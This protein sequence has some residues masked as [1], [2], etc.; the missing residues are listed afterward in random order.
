PTEQTTTPTTTSSEPPKETG[1]P[2]QGQILDGASTEAAPSPTVTPEQP[3][4]GVL[5]ASVLQNVEA[6]SLDLDNIDP[7]NSATLSTDK[8]D[9]APTDTAII[10]G[11]GFK[12]N[13]D[14]NITVSSADEPAT[15]T[16]D[17]ITTDVDG[18]FVY[19]YQL[20]GIYRPNYKVVVTNNGGHTIAATTFTD[21]AAVDQYSQCANDTGTGYTS[22]D[23]GCQWINGNLQS[24]NSAY[25][26]G[27]ATPQRL[28]LTGLINGTHTVVI[29]YGTT[30]GGKH[31]YDFVTDDTFSESWI[32]NAEFCEGLTGFGDCATLTPNLSSLI[33]TD[34]NA[35]GFDVA[36]ANR[37]F[38]IR[39]G[40]FVSVGTPTLISGSY[41]GDSETTILLTFNVD[42]NTC[43]NKVVDHGKNPN[44]DECPV[45]ITW[46]EHVSKQSDW[47]TGNSAVNISGSPYHVSLETVDGAS[48]GSRDNQMQAGAI[49][50]SI[51]II[52]DSQPNSA[53]DFSFT[54]TRTGLTSF[55]LDDDAD[56]TLS[57]TKFFG[58]LDAG[59][60][61]VSEI[62]ATGWT[63]SNITCVDPTQNSTSGLP[64]APTA[65][66]NLAAGENITCTFTNTQQN[67]HLTVQ[68]TT[69]PA[70]S[71]QSF[72]ITATGSGTI[73]GG[74]AGSITDSTDQTYEVTAGT[75]S[76]SETV[77]T[78]WTQTSNTCSNVVVAAGG[79]STCLITNTQKGHIVVRKVT[80]GADDTFTFT[81]G[82]TGYNGFSLSHGQSNDQEVIPGSYTVSE[83][84]LSGWSSDGGSCDN[85]ETPNSLDVEAG[86]TVTCTFTNTK[87]RNITA[88]KYDD[89]NG[90]GT[91][92]TSEPLLDGWNMTL[93][94][95]SV[96]QTTVNG[97]TTFTNLSPG[98]Y[99]IAET[100]KTDWANTTPLSQNVTLTSS[101]NETVYF[102]NFACATISGM[103]WEDTDGDG[104]KDTGEPALPD[105]TINLNGTQASDVTDANGQYSFKV[106]SAGT[107]TVTE[108]IPNTQVW[109]QTSPGGN[110]PNHQVE[111][112]S[113][114]SYTG[115]DFGNAKYA[116]IYG[117]KYRDND[118]DGTLDANDLTAT[119]SGWVFDLYDGTTNAV[120]GTY[121]TLSDGYYEFTGLLVNKT[122][123]VLEQLKPGWTQTIGPTPTPTPFAVQSGETKQ[124]NFANFEN[125]AV[126][127]CKVE[128][129]DGSLTTTTD[130]TPVSDWQ[131]DL[132][133][134]NQM[135]DNAQVTGRD[136]CYTW[137]NLTPGSYSTQEESQ[138][139]WQH[140]GSTSHDFGTLENGHT[141][142]HTFVNTHMGKII[143]EKQTLPDGNTQSFD[144]TADY[145]ANGF[146]LTDGAQNDSGFL[147]PG[148]Y[149][150]A[151]TGETGWDLTDASCSDQSEPTAIS[152][153]A[154]E[155]V[156]CTFTNTKRGHLIVQKTTI[157]ADDSNVFSI[158]ATGSG[159]ITGG[160]AGSISDD[161]DKNY[162]VTPGTYS[163][164]ETVPGNWD[165]TANT[166]TNVAVAAG[167]T[168][169][170]EITNTKRGHVT[171][172][173]YY[174]HDMDGTKDAGDQVLGDTGVG[175]EIEAT[176]WEI[177]LVGTDVNAYQW[178]GAQT[179]GQVTFSDLTPG[180]FTLSEQLKTG[181]LQSNISCGN[182]SAIDKDN[183][184]PVTVTAGQTTTCTIGNYEQGRIIVEKQTNPDGSNQEFDFSTNYDKNGF[185]LSDG[186]Q[187][188]S[189]YLNPGTY[190]VSETELTGWTLT[191]T[192][193]T[194]SNED[195]ESADNLQLDPG[196]TITCV[197]TNTKRGRIIVDKVTD[198]SRDQTAFAFT[199]SG[200]GYG[201]FFLSDSDEPNDQSLLP[202]SYAVSETVPT[203]WDLSSAI[204][205]SSHE[206]SE[207]VNSL[208][209][210]A[211]EVITCTFTNTKRGT[212]I[213][214]KYNDE[215]GNTVRDE[216]EDVLSGWTMNLNGDEEQEVTNNDGEAIFEHLLP[217]RYTLTEDLQKGWEQTQLSCGGNEEFFADDTADDTIDTGAFTLSP[218]ETQYCVVG[219]R[220]LNPILTITKDNNATGDKAPGENVLFTLTVTATQSAAFNVVVTDL[221]AA[222]FTYRSGSWTSVSTARGDLKMLG[223]TTEPAYHSPGVWILGDMVEN[224]TVTLTYI[225][226]ISSD[227]KPGLY[228]D[229]AWAY[230]CKFE[231]D[232]AVNDGNDVVAIAV[233]PGYIDETNHVGTGVNVVKSTQNGA[234]LNP[235][236]GEVLG[237]ST[238]LPAT[239]ADEAWLT[240]AALLFLMGIGLL[241]AGKYAR[242]LH[243]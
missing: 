149:S 4:E 3:E 175:S 26:E 43:A 15:S 81:T 44:P 39:N 193:C 183:S 209:L 145:D 155:T 147:M 140:L 215:N 78:G 156:T 133:K 172:I 12:P 129:A 174:D 144:F 52:K 71:Q 76:V 103:K 164:S 230:G 171:V 216:G 91:R 231:T 77:P 48:A 127:V 27:D 236:T 92:D 53:Q 154:G 179:A 67:G 1:P 93:T 98:N 181:W 187:N 70:G 30:K 210:S 194:S 217:G 2:E 177:H 50:G 136:G 72:A 62:A 222:G 167:E 54:T 200:S 143:V 38:K 224:E 166:C 137:T 126:T 22:G 130:R 32:T 17:T 212:V 104:V 97:C 34:S 185:V 206:D 8:A 99:S 240:F 135:Y 51:T 86:E 46:G 184:H 109:Y 226:D 165:Q 10:T 68:K 178:T 227:Q 122:Y 74:G 232:C 208:N 238:E 19:A 118:G 150:V 87:L 205:M 141:Y 235:T 228:K 56:V 201:N 47:G 79:N 73:T 128:D 202:G 64:T 176:R 146:A 95:G 9:Y 132:L 188:N 233:S 158:L 29:K 96:T 13:H 94:P 242:R 85:G 115:K 65:T 192:V 80:S 11:T 169:T 112:T 28:Y 61:T 69:I 160:G 168:K 229:L 6:A 131:I 5:H 121:T 59:S 63:L 125:M 170:C 21:S 203:G 107:F 157:P 37:H 186:E 58:N 83:T 197:F 49:K 106:C 33:P 148:T 16:T 243:V 134:N 57:N 82:G 204:C 110:S 237:A 89:T 120:L 116:K 20:D 75:Y 117:V 100:L 153:S 220:R 196:E 180:A 124:I 101:Q 213:V 40:N 161:T 36:Q 190:S 108:T 24:N 191:N 60:Y 219:N 173:K 189:G 35:G 55:N 207:S 223:I 123:Y 221:P 119:L 25:Y 182:E 199:A 114:G 218:G 151:E 234:T 214:T 23:T 159:T 198:P 152:L 195:T 138:S 102:G 90:N 225:A 41:A 111:V 239:G 163:V 211:G 88:C 7:S 241:T 18:A 45:L 42:T 139:G 113:G 142:S 66:I 31:A 14:Y 162:E 105:W 84:A